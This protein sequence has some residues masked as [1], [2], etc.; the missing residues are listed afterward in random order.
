MNQK[1]ALLKMRESLLTSR[2]ANTRDPFLRD[3]L[4]GDL[5][6]VRSQISA[7]VDIAA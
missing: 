2:I 3:N 4:S 6:S 7:L 5:R 1:L